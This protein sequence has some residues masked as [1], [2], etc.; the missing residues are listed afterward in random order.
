MDIETM[1]EVLCNMDGADPNDDAV[2]AEYLDLATHATN[3]DD[4][5]FF[6]LPNEF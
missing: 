2:W 1:A 6:D 3:T 5:I 4:G